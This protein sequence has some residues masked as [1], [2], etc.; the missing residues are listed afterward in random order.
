MGFSQLLF[1]YPYAVE[2]THVARHFCN[3]NFDNILKCFKEKMNLFPSQRQRRKASANLDR[4]VP[5]FCICRLPEEG[6]MVA[7]MGGDYCQK[8][9]IIIMEGSRFNWRVVVST[10]GQS[11][12]LEGSRFYQ[13]VVVSTGGQSFQL[14]STGGQWR[15]ILTHQE[16]R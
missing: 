15:V 14:V 4:K 12:L 8:W 7:C 5:V 11:F 16:Y 13:R 10:G 2:R 9:I 1:P 3:L 6:K